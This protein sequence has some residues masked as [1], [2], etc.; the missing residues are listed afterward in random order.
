MAVI[1]EHQVIA[2][3]RA[4]S[5]SLVVSL[6]HAP[7]RHKI[8]KEALRDHL[9]QA[10]SRS[11]FVAARRWL[12]AYSQKSIAKLLHEHVEGGGEIDQ[13]RERRPEYASRHEYHPDGPART[14]GGLL[15]AESGMPYER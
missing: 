3:N 6:P 13:V 8:L 14:L 15:T 7:A 1:Q 10:V 5:R 4:Q 9:R 12:G 2:R 11:V